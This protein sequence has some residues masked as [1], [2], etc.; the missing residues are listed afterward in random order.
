MHHT[1]LC[2]SS[3]SRSAISTDHGALITRQM[4]SAKI[5]RSAVE[6]ASEVTHSRDPETGAHLDRMSRFALAIARE[7]SASCAL[8]DEWLQLQHLLSLSPLHDIGKVATPVAVL[9]KSGRLDA[10]EFGI[11]KTHPARGAE[12]LQRLVERL[13]LAALPQSGM[14]RNIVW[15]HR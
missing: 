15:C 14:L 9:L 2:M 8:S 10:R 11:M 5:L 1:L 3:I 12:M 6:V 4:V 13:G 7:L